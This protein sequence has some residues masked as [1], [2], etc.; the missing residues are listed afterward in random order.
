[1]T[2]LWRALEDAASLMEVAEVWQQR[3]GT[4][5]EPLSRFF[6]ATNKLASRVRFVGDSARWKV[7]EYE[8]RVIALNEE[9][10]EHRVL[11]RSDAL[12]RRIDVR[13]LAKEICESLG[14]SPKFEMLGRTYHV[15]RIGELPASLKAFPVYLCIRKYPT[16]V[17]RAIDEVARHASGPFL[18]VLPTNRSLD[19]AATV[20]LERTDGKIASAADLLRSSDPS[21][22][23]AQD[24]ARSKL[25][26]V[27]GLEVTDSPRY[28]FK[29]IGSKHRFIAFDSEPTVVKESPG[30][31]Y[32]AALLASPRQAIHAT[33]LEAMRT[34]VHAAASTGSLGTQIDEEAKRN[35]GIR[36]R[37]LMEEIEDTKLFAGEERL[38][39]LHTERESIVQALQSATQ[40]GDELREDS[41]ADRARQSV[42]AAIRRGYKAIAV[43]N[44]QLAD[45]LEDRIRLGHEIV[46]EPPT[47][48]DWDL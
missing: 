34:G 7:I 6:I 45:Y 15:C 2:R 24:D 36:L 31:Y 18:F 47:V 39:E 38:A 35:Y 17:V 13:L 29:L 48:L 23:V 14:W 4:E 8:D 11:Q 5:F 21:E 33:E 9:T 27:L 3:L 37:E 42:C 10:F 44:R 30:T 46:Y 20:W 40:R 25:Q 12:L 43:E 41:D 22:L 16:D 32:L 1:M 26:R 28:Q 19:T